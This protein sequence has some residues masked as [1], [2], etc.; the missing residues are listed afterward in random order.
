M[1]QLH[2]HLPMQR[3]ESPMDYLIKV[4]DLWL[5]I[6]HPDTKVQVN[7]CKSKCGMNYSMDPWMIWL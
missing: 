5:S 6:E 1:G 3:P 7:P 2:Q 4:Q